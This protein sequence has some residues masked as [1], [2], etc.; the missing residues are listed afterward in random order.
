MRLDRATPRVCAVVHSCYPRDPRVRREA[1]ALRDAGMDVEVICLRAEGQLPKE[2]IHGVTVRRLPCKHSR[3]SALATFVSYAVFFLLAFFSV[4]LRQLRRGYDLVHVHNMPDFL[5]FVAIVPRLFGARVLLDLHDPMPEVF[6]AKFGDREDH[7][8]LRLLRAQERICIRFADAVL[9]PNEAF[10]KVFIERG[11]PENKIRIV[12]NTPQ[13]RVFYS[14]PDPR[15]RPLDPFVLMYHGSMIRR[16]GMGILLRALAEHREALEPFRMNVF[17][18][19]EY[20]ERFQALV[21][22]LGLEDVIEYH[23]S[24]THEEIAESLASCDLGVIPNLHSLQWDL[25]VPTRVFEY[26]SMGKPAVAPRTRGILDYLGDDEVFFFD[27]GD[28]ASLGETLLEARWDAEG[29]KQRATEGQKAY[30]CIRWE[31]QEAR[32]VGVVCSLLQRS[33]RA[34]DARSREFLG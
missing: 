8:L 3:K 9:T 17:G 27:S 16:Y 1:E 18:G 11:C 10:R 23:G 15:E 28:Q 20:V 5:V 22:E 29:L 31:L 19:G 13:E 14:R 21:V 12:M 33:F 24:V 4:S 25:A 2:V 34:D 26:L 30:Q 6:R 32:L 7:W